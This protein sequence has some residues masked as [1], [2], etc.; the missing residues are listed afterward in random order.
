MVTSFVQAKI[1]LHVGRFTATLAGI[2]LTIF[3]SW[4]LALFYSRTHRDS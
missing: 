3:M 1:L 2:A 4:R